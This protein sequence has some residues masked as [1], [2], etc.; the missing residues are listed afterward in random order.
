MI[1]GR[2]S[3]FNKPE[4]SPVPISGGENKFFFFGLFNQLDGVGPVGNSP[5]TD[6]FNH[7]CDM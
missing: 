7:F 1:N 3:K 5:S 6:N 4:Q 2:I